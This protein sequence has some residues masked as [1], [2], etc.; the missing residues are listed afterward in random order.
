MVFV[1][2]AR[3]SSLYLF[4][5]TRV[6]TISFTHSAHSE[7]NVQKAELERFKAAESEGFREVK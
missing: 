5:S 2:S 4:N 6:I 3:H 7:I 1:P